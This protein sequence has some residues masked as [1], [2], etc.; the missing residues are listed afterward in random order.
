MSNLLRAATLFTDLLASE[1]KG[2]RLYLHSEA[3][4]PRAAIYISFLISFIRQPG[5]GDEELDEN[6]N[7]HVAPERLLLTL[8]ITQRRLRKEGN[9]RS[10]SRVSGAILLLVPIRSAAKSRDSLRTAQFMPGRARLPRAGSCLLHTGSHLLHTGSHLL[11]IRSYPFHA[12]SA[13]AA[14]VSYM[15]VLTSWY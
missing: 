5:E 14:L 1:R 8:L 3:A 6:E 15:V 4:F 9:R 13:W 2:I 11:H 10:S 12:T 7:D